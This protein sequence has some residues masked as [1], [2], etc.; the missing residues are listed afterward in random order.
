MP[1]WVLILICSLLILLVVGGILICISIRKTNKRTL[2]E[3][4]RA[5]MR[6][7]ANMEKEDEEVNIAELEKYED[8]PHKFIMASDEK[9]MVTGKVTETSKGNGKKDKTKN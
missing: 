2:G 8:K 9:A 3:N 1:N 6:E 4:E 7:L 5:I